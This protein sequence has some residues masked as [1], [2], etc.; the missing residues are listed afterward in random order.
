MNI[1]R[2]ETGALTSTIKIEVGKQDYDEKVT[3]TLREQQRKAAM[4]GFRPGKVPYGMIRKMFGKSI[5]L[6]EINKLL[7]E[8][9]NNYI[10]ENNLRVIGNPL[11]N[12][13]KSPPID[14]DHQEDFEFYFDIGIA[15]EVNV[16]L[17]DKIAVEYYDIK[18]NDKLIDEYVKDLR[19]R[20][21]GHSHPEISGEKDV[22][23][24]EMVELDETGAVKETGIRNRTALSIDLIK[25][26]TTRKEFTG[27]KKGDEVRIDLQKAI[28]NINEISYL[29]GIKKEQAEGIR[30]EFN[31]I[32]SEITRHQDAELNEEF[33]KK[34]FPD[35]AIKDEKSFRAKVKESI[36]K[37]LVRE[38]DRF[39]MNKAVEKLVET[40]PVDLPDDF[41]KRW[42]MESE[43]NPA[44]DEQ[45]D[46]QYDNFAKSVR[47]QLIETNLIKSHGIQVDESEVRG[48][49]RDYFA[50]QMAFPAEDQEAEK[51]L[52]SIIDSV[53]QNKE[54]TGKIHDQLFEGKLL[55]LFKNTLKLKHKPID[56]D[57]FN[58]IVTQG[59]K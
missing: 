3:R 37:S 16:E 4:P 49:V 47:W 9:L 19:H 34:V 20:L 38:S 30:S 58:K 12:K 48:V 25:D 50:G 13:E 59:N 40:T 45:L 28:G 17:G 31:F 51:R 22:L 54:E 11:P 39:F 42:L 44:T 15:P 41:I 35:E 53:M 1:S 43:E 29:L 10:V 24:G 2:E 14:L 46:S 33:Y 32:I 56:Y 5:L 57:E 27:K 8:E 23:Q 52:N 36:E 7:A 21:G 55:E 6:D 26:E 18:A